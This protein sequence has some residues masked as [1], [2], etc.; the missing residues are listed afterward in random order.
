VERLGYPA[1]TKLLIVHADDMGVAHAQ[2]AATFAALESGA[3]SSGSVMVPAPWAPEAIAWASKHP[4][5]DIGIHLTLTAEWPLLRWGG[6]LSRAQAPSLYDEHGFLPASTA[7]LA[8]HARADEVE[9]ELRAQ[10]ARARELG[11]RPTHLDTHMAGVMVTP[12]I[13]AAYLRVARENHIPAMIPG[14]LLQN[15]ALLG[16][17]SGLAALV[18]PEEILVDHYV[19]AMGNLPPEQWAAFYTGVIQKL[20]PGSI[21]QLIVH[22]AYDDAEMRAVTGG[23]EAYGAA[24][25][26]RDLDFFM[27]PAAKKLLA[28]NGVR[29]TTW[30]ELSKLLAPAS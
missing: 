11:L 26:Q 16:A 8:R 7:E 14:E 28:E 2:D 4:D 12:E 13:F 18:K 5:A 25:R 29:L 27:S 24:W 1:G 10:L 17:A 30:R 20:E 19:M 23:Q 6:V 22:L 3:A 15:P 21:T 9:K